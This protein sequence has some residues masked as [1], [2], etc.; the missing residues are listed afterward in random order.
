[1]GRFGRDSL[2]EEK[3]PWTAIQNCTS[4]WEISWV[5]H[6]HI[7]INVILNV[8][9]PDHILSL[10]Q[11]LAHYEWMLAQSHPI[12]HTQL[13]VRAVKTKRKGNMAA[14]VL[15]V[16]SIGVVLIQILIGGYRSNAKGFYG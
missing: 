6:L 5:S 14:V 1:M 2:P 3:D 8:G 9:T 11:G 4:T 10:Q 12:Y 16:I 7:Q 15:T 13:H